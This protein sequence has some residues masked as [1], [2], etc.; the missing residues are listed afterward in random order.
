MSITTQEVPWTD[1]RV[2][3]LHEALFAETGALYKADLDALTPDG[4]AAARASLAVDPGEIVVTLLMLDG[5]KPVATAAV[6]PSHAAPGTEWEVKRVYVAED[7]RGRGL[8]KALRLDLHERAIAAGMATIVL[9]TGG[10]QYAAHALYEGLGYERVE[11]YP[12][13]GFFPGERY[14]RA[15]L[16]PLSPRR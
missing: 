8:S 16:T 3:A 12:P 14:Y 10:L 5:T 7:Y 9:Q 2:A 13:Y 15:T 6:R 11:V 1:P 4:L